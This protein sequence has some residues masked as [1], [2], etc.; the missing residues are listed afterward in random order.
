MSRQSAE[1][2]WEIA[3]EFM[4]SRQAELGMTTYRLAKEANMPEPTVHR[5]MA[6][7]RTPSVINVIQLL[8]AL[9]IN[10]HLVTK[11]EDPLPYPTMPLPDLS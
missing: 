2:A 6:G 10:P 3:L 7:Q 8:T 4:R 5:I 1:Q 9:R 11:E